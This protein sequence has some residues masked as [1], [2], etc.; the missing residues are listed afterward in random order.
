[1]KLGKSPLENTKRKPLVISKEIV[2]KY[3]LKQRAKRDLKASHNKEV[4]EPLFTEAFE[5]AINNKT[6]G[7][8]PF[9]VGL[10]LLPEVYMN[11]AKNNEKKA[12]IL[13]G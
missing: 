11:S 7:R 9:W 6:N 5:L 4:L 2:E 1:M 3:H 13:V 8:N 10:D 12:V